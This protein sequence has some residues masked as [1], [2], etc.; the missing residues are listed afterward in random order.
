MIWLFFLPTITKVTHLAHEINFP[1]F[2]VSDYDAH[3][4]PVC[5]EVEDVKILEQILLACRKS[6]KV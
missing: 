6:E 1:G 3:A 2:Q 5:V 4:L